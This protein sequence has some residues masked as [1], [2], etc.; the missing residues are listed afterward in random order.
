MASGEPKSEPNTAQ[1][2]LHVS[3]NL[4]RDRGDRGRQREP[5]RD[6][7][8]CNTLSVGILA[9]GVG[10]MPST[11]E[12]VFCSQTRRD[13]CYKECKGKPGSL[14]A[15]LLDPRLQTKKQG[16]ERGR[17]T[18]RAEGEESTEGA[19][20][21]EVN[22]VGTAHEEKDKKP[23]KDSTKEEKA[24]ED[25][26]SK[27]KG[28]AEKEKQG[29]QETA[30]ELQ[31]KQARNDAKKEKKARSKEKRKRKAAAQDEK[32]RKKEKEKDEKEKK[33]RKK[34]K[35]KEDQS[36]S[37][38]EVEP[39]SVRTKQKE[40]KTAVEEEALLSVPPSLLK[41]FPLKNRAP[42]CGMTTTFS[43]RC[44]NLCAPLKHAHCVSEK[45]R[46]SPFLCNLVEDAPLCCNE[47][48]LRFLVQSL[49]E[50]L[51][52]NNQADKCCD[53]PCANTNTNT[54]TNTNIKY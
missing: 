4:S 16:E 33:K 40:A 29:S 43:D 25:G 2:N 54:N 10:K 41:R 18:R 21:N 52:N 23:R 27:R 53:W 35:E 36:D 13:R 26:K 49:K 31:D 48:C 17:R 37:E 15:R 32:E 50:A 38:A 39:E 3:T 6:K 28:D 9:Q 42:N 45:P 11:R 8:S 51:A 5:E 14:S 30:N 1:S 24:R 46:L 44:D 20:A 12:C 34:E 47:H 7:G 22:Y 19:E